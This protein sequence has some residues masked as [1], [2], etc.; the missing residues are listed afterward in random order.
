MDEFLELTSLLLHTP[1]RA[2]PSLLAHAYNPNAL[3][4]QQ[5]QY[6]NPQTRS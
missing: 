5:P 3:D 4:T 2:R 1:A 6:F